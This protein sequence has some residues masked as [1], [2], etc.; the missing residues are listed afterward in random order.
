MTSFAAVALDTPVFS[1]V[2]YTYLQEFELHTGDW[3]V[4]DFGTT[5]KVGVVWQ[6]PSE[7]TPI[8]VDKVRP[9]VRKLLGIPPLRADW[10]ILIE[11]A[12]K[13]YQR[14]I[15]EVAIPAIPAHLRRSTLR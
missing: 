10:R 1:L 12:A 3:V 9:I 5:Q 7:Q 11:F 13:Y 4:V 8:A 14:G 15:G 2:D 6:L